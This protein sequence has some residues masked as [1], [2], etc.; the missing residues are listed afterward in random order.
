MNYKQKDIQESWKNLSKD[1][2]KELLI[3]LYKDS[4]FLVS[5]EEARLHEK[6]GSTMNF[7]SVTPCP[8]CGK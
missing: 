3:E 2:K 4:D 7:G 8:V 1:E 6:K 5:I